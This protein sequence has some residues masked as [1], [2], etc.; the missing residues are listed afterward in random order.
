MKIRAGI[1]G[2]SDSVHLI[3]DIAKE[4]SDRLL[5]VPFVYQ[6]TEEATSIMQQNQSSV[7]L[8]VFAGPALYN[9][10][11]KSGSKQ[12]FYYLRLD[13]ASLTKTLAEIGYK[14]GFSLERM[15]ID[16]L[17]ERDVY[18]TYRDLNIPSEQVYVHEYSHDTPIEDLLSFHITLFKRGKVDI[19]VT[20]LYSIYEELVS[21]G[22][23]AY[24][25]SPTRSNIRETLSTAI[26][27][28]ETMHFKQSQIAA[29]LVK[30][31]KMEKK[32]DYNMVS[33]D[34][35][36][37]NL[38]IQSAVISFSESISGSFMTLGVGTFIIF[39]TRGSIQETGMQVG[40]LLE[41]LAL[42]T[43]SPSNVGIGYGETALAAEENARLAL[44]H[45]QN[46]DAFCAFLVDAGGT[47]EG[48]LKEEE[49]ISF[50]YRTE[51]KEISEKL[52]QCGVTITTF[53]KIL[54]V[55]KRMGSHSITASNIAEWL[56]MTPRNARR[57]LNSL[58]EE[59]IAEI[60]GEEAPT[61]KGRPR[62]IYRVKTDAVQQST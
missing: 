13:A 46:Y 21:Q 1:V 51:N 24:W 41:T 43:E 55:Q 18:E 19:C 50:G 20:C 45:A 28:W 22:I 12:P 4:Y 38:E 35:H 25:V 53:N 2:P 29:L 23:T 52:K 58:V 32:T 37:L 31:E 8:W 17:T 16:M 26:Q 59:G 56:K 39:S 40:S 60:I 27:Q 9:P 36:R 44:N 3:G 62:K 14:G 34:L 57:I 6:N 15:S 47:I 48:P 42:I 30:V 5:P 7:D 54:S 11:Q 33:Y 49:I 61:S 10:A